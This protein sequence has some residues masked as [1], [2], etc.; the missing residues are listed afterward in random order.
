MTEHIPSDLG[1]RMSKG[2]AWMI[3]MRVTVRSLGFASTIILARLLVPDD[4]GLI[5]MAML[6]YGL[7]EVL[8]EFNF[9]VFLIRE[10]YADRQ[11]Y[12]TAWTMSVVRGLLMGAILYAA[13]PL[14]AEALGDARLQSIVRIIALCAVLEGLINIG[15]VDFRKLLNFASEFRFLTLAKLISFSVTIFAAFVLRSYWALVLGIVTH[16]AAK[17]VLSYILHP[18][19]PRFGLR[20]ARELFGF[21]KWLLLNGVLNYLH[22]RADG[23]IV[24]KIAGA[25]TLGLY[26]VANEIATL[27][28]SKLIAPIHRALLPGYAKLADDPVRMRRS[29][30]DGLAVIMLL[31]APLAVGIGVVADPL[32][33]LI[34]GDKWL[35]C[36]PLIQILAVSGLLKTCRANSSP[37]YL[38]MG[39]PKLTTLIAGTTV[40]VGLP[41]V[42]WATIRWGA[43][44]TAGA[45][46]VAT[47][48]SVSLNFV[49]LVRACGLPAKALVAVIWRTLTGCLGMS[50]AVIWALTFCSQQSNIA[51][52]TMQLLVLA[53]FGAATY[54]ALILGLWRISGRPDGGEALVVRALLDA[55]KSARITAWRGSQAAG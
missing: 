53:S 47:F 31:T 4:F 27:A 23:L 8:S 52:L 26:T 39:Y 28:T 48:V 9:S 44:G 7:L 55:C 33:R 22:G 41:L 20:H 13:A 38:A 10:Q 30:V 36:V 25:A 35:D 17:V 11:L 6:L 3:L 34:L 32:V 19:K 5:A 49:L 40:I 14:A 43:I 1:R 51:G 21:S 12:D 16:V 42:I 46:G 37:L 29:F 15:V 24:G 54:V 45:V 18:F 50:A 2:A